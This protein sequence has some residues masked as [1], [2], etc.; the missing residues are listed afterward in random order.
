MQQKRYAGRLA[1]VLS[2]LCSFFFLAG[3]GEQ[4]NGMQITNLQIGKDGRVTSNIVEAF[5][6]G[7][8]TIEGLEAMIQEEITAYNANHP[9]AVVLKTAELCKEDESKVLVTME[10]ASD[11]D[12]AAFNK[13]ELFFGTVAEAEA[14]GF[15]LNVELVSAADENIKL[16]KEDIAGMTDSH[17][18]IIRENIQVLLP[19]KVLYMTAGT[20]LINSKSINVQKADGLTYVIMK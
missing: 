18:L 12:Y 6:K 10:Y 17:I 9:E 15:E 19:E 4:K 2:V 3:C 8:Y 7:F 5:E 16:T 11:A 20:E 1:A 13:E 14:A